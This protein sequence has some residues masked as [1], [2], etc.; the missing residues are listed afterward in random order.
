MT[1]EYKKK[2][3]FTGYHS[4][5]QNWPLHDGKGSLIRPNNKLTLP[6]MRMPRIVQGKKAKKG[7]FPYQVIDSSL[8]LN[9][10]QCL[11]HLH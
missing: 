9:H 3:Y 10:G 8:P 4:N 1:Y 11:S 5:I 7:Q 6:E 2:V